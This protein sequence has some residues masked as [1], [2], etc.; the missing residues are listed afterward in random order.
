MGKIQDDVVCVADD[1]CENEGGMSGK[2]YE[3]LEFT[4]DF[5]F[6]KILESQPGLCKELA[7]MITEEKLGKI[8]ADQSQKS[9]RILPGGHGVRFDV[10]LSDGKTECDIEMQTAVK[11]SLPKRSRYYQSTIDVST[12]EKSNDYTKLKK[13]FIIFIVLE[14]PFPGWDMKKY[15]FVNTCREEKTLELGDDAVKI[16]LT[17]KGKKGKLSEEMEAF[18]SYIAEKKTDSD[19]TRELEKQ[20]KIAKEGGY[21]RVEYMQMREKLD[22]SKEEGR[23]EGIKEG[24]KEGIK[25]GRKEECNNNIKALLKSGLLS[26]KEIANVFNISEEEVK[27]LKVEM[28][29]Q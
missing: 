29:K 26:E 15:T 10:F 3:E 6:C 4:D 7:E 18:M 12:F 2:S 25:E 14:N 21:W 17:P 16:F 1:V 20:V 9:I 11:D 8:K 13:S 27:R 22:E 23:K 28:D 19:L 5:M 24:R